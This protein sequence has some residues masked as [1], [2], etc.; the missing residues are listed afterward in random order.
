M[1]FRVKAKR[2]MAAAVEATPASGDR[3]ARTQRLLV[4][5]RRSVYEGARR[6]I[7]YRRIRRPTL[8]RRR[9]RHLGPS[10]RFLIMIRNLTAILTVVT[11][12]F[13]PLAASSQ[14]SSGT[15]L[16]GTIDQSLNSKDAQVGQ[17]FTLS[18]VH[19]PNYN[20]NGGRIYGHVT[21]VQRAGQGTQGKMQ[22]AFDKINTRAGN[23]YHL[24]ANATNVQVN[25][26]SNAGKEAIGA[27]AGALVGGLLG[28]GLGAVIGGAGGYLVAK[29][30]RENVTIPQGSLVTVQVESGRRQASH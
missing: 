28:K 2:P 29:N 10:F 1:I 11:L 9:A 24:E 30:N 18:N 25:T 21:A 7:A 17:S 15:Q 20:V 13:A 22:L 3:V 8:L 6:R 14:I 23:I 16:V 5:G 4:D 27:G 12:G 26:K 19:S